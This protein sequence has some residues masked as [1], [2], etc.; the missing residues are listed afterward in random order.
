[1]QETLHGGDRRI[2]QD[3]R[4]GFEMGGQTLLRQRNQPG[5]VC[6][7]TGISP[8]PGYYKALKF[9]KPTI[10]PGFRYWN[11]QQIGIANFSQ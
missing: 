8:D 4:F 11:L 2:L 7:G 10:E 9:F 1:M 3:Q 6:S 5:I